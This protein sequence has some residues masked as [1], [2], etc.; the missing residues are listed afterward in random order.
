MFQLGVVTKALPEAEKVAG[1]KED[2]TEDR[3]S[4]WNQRH[5]SHDHAQQ[6]RLTSQTHLWLAHS[7]CV[8]Q[9]WARRV[10]CPVLVTRALVCSVLESNISFSNVRGDAL[11]CAGQLPQEVVSSSFHCYDPFLQLKPTSGIE[12]KTSTSRNELRATALVFS[13]ENSMVSLPK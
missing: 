1:I 13:A 10:V 11:R 2:V 9:Q 8:C 3:P 7:W 4:R 6:Q 12:N 5:T